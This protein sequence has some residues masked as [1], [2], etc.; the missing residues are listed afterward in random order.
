MDAGAQKAAG[1]SMV[2]IGVA[3]S[4]P[5][6]RQALK[7]ILRKLPEFRLSWELDN[8]AD[9]HA[10]LKSHPVHLLV[11]DPAGR[12]TP[13][14][15]RLVEQVHER[16]SRTLVLV[17]TQTPDE[18]FAMAAFRAGAS[19][20]LPKDRSILELV[21]ALR[22]IASGKIYLSPAQ[23]EQFS[24]RFLLK[25]RGLSQSSRLSPREQAVLDGIAAGKRLKEIAGDL[26]LSPKTVYTYKARIMERFQLKSNADLICFAQQRTTSPAAG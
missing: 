4:C 13:D 25:T 2:R 18:A 16:F 24:L 23:S 1:G 22:T 12:G 11:L 19:G 15:A 9:I 26:F 6:I 10:T 20:V 14:A 17:Y 3:D 7:E 21:S 5:L 8:A